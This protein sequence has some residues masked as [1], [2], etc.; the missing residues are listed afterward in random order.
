MSKARQLAFI[1]EELEYLRDQVRAAEAAEASQNTGYGRNKKSKNQDNR[2][3]K[4]LE[5]KIATRIA[6]YQEL[7][8]KP[9][10]DVVTFEETGKY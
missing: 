10:D 6:K 8:A 9:K 5:A 1:N 4:A 2:V 3:V 7:F